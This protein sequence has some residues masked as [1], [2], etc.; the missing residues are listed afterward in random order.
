MLRH[1]GG[2]GHHLERGARTRTCEPGHARVVRG[3]RGVAGSGLAN[4][5]ISKVRTLKHAPAKD[6]SE[7]VLLRS[8][9]ARL[10]GTGTGT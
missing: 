8:P 5:G 9:V 10:C 3:L 6:L 1:A 4:L 7:R 2:D